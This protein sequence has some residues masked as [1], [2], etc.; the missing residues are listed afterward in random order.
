MTIENW[1]AAGIVFLVGSYISNFPPTNLAT[2]WEISQAL[3]HKILRSSDLSFLG[4]D[5]N[6]IPFEAIMQC[7]PNR[8]LIR[9]IIQKLFCE[10]KANAVHHCLFSALQSGKAESL[11]TTNYDLAFDSL[12]AGEPGIVTVFDSPSFDKYRRL[13]S[14]PSFSPKVYFKIHGTAAP[15]AEE[16]IVCDLEAEGWLD[17]W[18]RDLLLEVTS[19]RTLVVIGYSGRDFD[20]CP[21]LASYTKQAHT[22]WLQPHRG[23]LQPNARRV[24]TERQ[25][26]L[27]EGDLIDFLRVLLDED[28]TVLAPSPQLVH[29]NYF[30]PALTDEWRLQILNWIACPTLLSESFSKLKDRPVL[31]RALFGHSG[32]YRD[33]VREFESE[34]RPL[35]DSRDERLRRTIDLVSARFIYGQHVRAWLM[36]NRVDK[37]LLDYKSAPKDL[38]AR[39]IETRMIMY[40]RA[41]QVARALR[42]KPLLR[43]IQGKASPRYDDAMKMLQDLGAWGRLEALQQNAERIGVA[44]L[45]GLPLPSRWGYRCLG[46]VSM[47]AITKRDWIRSGRWRLSPEKEREALKCIAKAKQ[48][49]WHHEAWKLNWI[50]F[51]RGT[52]N[53]I[54]Y[55]RAWKEYFRATQ[56]PPLARI[57]QLLLNLVPVGPERN[58]EDR[59]YWS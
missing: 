3:W 47:D 55:F 10:M 14:A 18:K 52:G 22:V 6:D 54:Q 58:F 8:S 28:L 17:A 43:Y 36:L 44:T 31:R 11:I 57:L 38:R 49:G 33:A 26:V 51:L 13:R 53:R 12:T 42:L 35:P 1:R 56:Y 29:L 59:H 40:M 19:D 46:L 2:G 39:A 4:E 48:Y 7:Y 21:E 23:A 34:L 30:D 37:R 16:T 24:L 41:A 45:R 9:P 25:G 27:V 15:G 20:I 32:R 5:L 50:M